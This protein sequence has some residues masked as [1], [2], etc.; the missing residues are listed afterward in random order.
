MSQISAEMKT[1]SRMYYIRDLQF[2]SALG[3]PL[4]PW[5]PLAHLT[6]H[7]RSCALVRFGGCFK[8]QK[9]ITS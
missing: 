2:H 3:R 4:D 7:N 5:K 6:E 9:K 8:G 1:S